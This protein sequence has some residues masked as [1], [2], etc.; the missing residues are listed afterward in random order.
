MR[1]RFGF[2]IVVRDVVGAHG[3]FAALGG[4]FRVLSTSC[5]SR[6]SP[7]SSLS[8][9][10]ADAFLCQAA[11]SGNR[12]PTTRA[13]KQS[14]FTSFAQADLPTDTSDDMV[15]EGQTHNLATVLDFLRHGYVG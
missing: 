11:F 4:R 7:L 5:P 2:V 3:R 13:L 6:K 14:D 10:R 1:C 12:M 9:G 15:M 8:R